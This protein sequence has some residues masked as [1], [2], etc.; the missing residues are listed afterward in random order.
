MRN[1]V[2]VTILLMSISLVGCSNTETTSKNQQ[3]EIERL[4]EEVAALE[5]TIT[6]QESEIDK[7]KEFTYL[8]EL[9]EEEMTAYQ[10]FVEDYDMAHLNG[11]SPEN[12]VLLYLHSV[13]TSDMNAIYAMTYDG[14]T[15]PD[16]E[17]FTTRFYAQ[18]ISQIQ[19]DEV[20][21]YKDYDSI[22]VIDQN[23]TE[24]SQTVEITS[25]MGTHSSSSLYDVKK[26]DGQ[27]KMSIQHW[28]EEF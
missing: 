5:K 12:I 19:H 23:K 16:F 25:S 10:L 13:A 4:T 6:N 21:R 9:S 11:Y 22:Q 2:M 14:G 8:R 27:W 24:E 7:I 20:F 26:E 15:L 1:K 17:T 28:L 3:D 18:E